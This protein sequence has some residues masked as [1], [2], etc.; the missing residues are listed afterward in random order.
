[1][2]EEP[3]EVGLTMPIAWT[4]VAVLVS[5]VA[6]V[7]VG[8]SAY[9][10]ESAGVTATSLAVLPVGFAVSGAIGAVVAHFV[11]RKPS[12]GRAAV[13]LG[14]G[15]VGALTLAFG[16]FVFFAVIFPML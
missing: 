1:M 10:S 7:A 12:V 3:N 4:L 5:L 6:A 11:F 2:D 15:C 8:A 13:P 16:S 14:C 9:N